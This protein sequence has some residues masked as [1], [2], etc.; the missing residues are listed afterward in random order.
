MKFLLRSLTLSLELAVAWAGGACQSG[1]PQIELREDVEINQETISLAD[2]LPSDASLA[3][4]TASSAIELGSAPQPGSLRVWQAPQLMRK[5]VGQ[6]AL[7]SQILLPATIT[8]RRAGWPIPRPAIASAIN[9]F[10]QQQGWRGSN[11]PDAHALAWTDAAALVENPAL[12]VT[13]FEWDPRQPALQLQLRCV[14]RS[15]CGSFLVRAAIPYPPPTAPPRTSTPEKLSSSPGARPGLAG[16]SVSEPATGRALAQ[17]GDS[18]T[19]ILEN[20]GIRISLAVVCLQRGFLRQEIRV[21]DAAGQRVYR[22]EVVGAGLLR[23]P[24]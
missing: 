2:L 15:D 20:D 16:A 8:V 18:A 6:S 12:E 22:A 7:L 5:L 21:R 17:P 9:G 4:R 13:A 1:T 14:K 11:L 24:L 10:L 23:A 19:L 3:L